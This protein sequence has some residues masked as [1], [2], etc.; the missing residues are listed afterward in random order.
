[1]T[2]APSRTDREKPLPRGLLDAL[3]A[4]L[5]AAAIFLAFGHA[6]LNYD[7][8]YALLWG[9]ELAAGRLP[10]YGAPVAPTPH[11]LVT[12]LGIPLSLLGAAGED[13]LL[14]LFLLGFG[15]L[16]VGVFRL[17]SELFAWPVGLLAAGILATRVPPLNFGI[18]GY[19]DLPTAAL[20]VWA[21]VLE[22]RRPRRGAPVLVLLALAGL[23]RPEAWL[24]AGAYWLWLAP[25]LAPGAR[26]RLAALAAAGPALWALSD[27]AVTGNPLWSFQGTNELAGRL[28][29]PTGLDDVWHIGP[30]RLGEILRLPE[31]LAAVAGLMAGAAL[32]RRRVVLP[33]ALAGLNG[34][35]YLTFAIAGLPLLGRYLL[36]AGAM[37]ALLAA[38]AAL[39][40]TALGRGH[41]ARRPWQAGG[42]LVLLA[43]LAFAPAQAGRL[44]DLR[45][46]IAARDRIQSDLLDLTRR[47]EVRFTL[48]RCRPLYLPNHR[49]VPELSYWTG[50]PPA[51]VRSA[52]LER[53]GAR[54]TFIS[55]A[56]P[57][58][59][60]LSILDP[61]DPQRLDAEVP[62]RY[63]AVVRNRSW[64]LSSGC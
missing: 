61:K 36:L 62:A 40:W 64:V 45:T 59:E 19:V 54:G 42:A 10:N 12:L 9:S 46:D 31:L 22:L 6:F 13:V 4:V 20:I 57:E 16:V 1:M 53:P 38:V 5:V 17:G 30:R 11:P 60:R 26:V 56:T 55:P 47:P 33:L 37:L 15:A 7:S 8:F 32:L 23:L 14:A 63:D 34:L 3:A 29:R 51:D 41:P 39:G 2:P 18:R 25:A 52:G 44:G 28:E 35:A 21:G 50:L 48:Q 24:F 43:F 27:L 49:R 58:V